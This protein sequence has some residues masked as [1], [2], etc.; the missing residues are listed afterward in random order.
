MIDIHG[1]KTKPLLKKYEW[2]SIDSNDKKS[3][4]SGVYFICDGGYHPWSKL[5]SPYKNQLD[6][7]HVCDWSKHI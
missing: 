7:S 1:P 2:T 5:M 6:G 4:R 3:K